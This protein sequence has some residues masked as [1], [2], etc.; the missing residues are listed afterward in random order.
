[1]ASKTP[2][3]TAIGRSPAVSAVST[4]S[5]TVRA[6]DLTTRV[7]A[8]TP[9]PPAAP[10]PL[11]AGLSDVSAA[12]T[13][14][15]HAI[16]TVR[17]VDGIV[18]LVAAPASRTSLF[19]ASR[20]GR[21]V[22]R[23][24]DLLALRIEL[25]NLKVTPGTP[26]LL[27]RNAGGAAYIV[28]HLPP[29]SIAEKVFFETA[30]PGMSDPDLPPGAQVKGSEPTTTDAPDPPPIRA[31][32]AGESRLVFKVPATFSVPYTLAGVLEACESL[33]PNV[34]ANAL[35]GSTAER[36]LTIKDFTVADLKLLSSAQRI[37]LS[38]LALRNVTV[39]AVDGA[40]SP[41][42][43]FRMQMT[44]AVS[45]QL[46][47][48]TRV[49]R[50]VIPSLPPRPAL[51]AAT[52]TA[53]ELPWRL[54]IAPHTGE[55]FRHAATPVTSALT[56]RTELWHSRL[57]A[58][59]A[60]G[61]WIE[62]PRPDPT[63]TTRAVWA[64]TGEGSDTAAPMS[65][66]FPT[67]GTLPTTDRVT[68]P[69]LTTLDDFDRYQIAHLSSNFS[70]SS[71]TPQP[72][73]TNLL[74]LSSLGGWLDARGAWDP[75]GLSV[76]EWVHRATM[77]RDHY[78]RVVYKGFLYPFGHRVALIK[79]SERKFHNGRSNTPVRA[80][81]PAYLRQRMFIIVRERER[82]FADGQ[83]RSADG[84]RAFQR[85][86]PFHQVRILTEV[87]P[88]LDPPTTT[89]S[90]IA[91]PPYA[92]KQGS[93]YF[94]Q[95]MFWPCVG[96]TPFRFRCVGTDSDGQRVQFELPLI[97]MDNSLASPRFL[98]GGK[99]VPLFADRT[100]GGKV[101]FGAETYARAA[102]DEWLARSDGGV[103][104]V[105]RRQAELKRQRVALAPS[106]KAGDTA[107]EVEVMEFGG[108]W[109]AQGNALRTY[110]N[111]LSRPV[112]YPSV[113]SV[114]VR[115]AALAQLGGANASNLLQWNGAYLQHGFD[116]PDVAPANAKNKGQVFAEVV[117]EQG[118]AALD[119]STQ[120]DR[121]GGFVMP[122]LKPSGLSRSLGPLTGPV[123]KFV[124][125]ASLG[126]TE[127]FPSSLS[128]LPLP[129]LFG[130]IP[131]GE[132][133]KAVAGGSDRLPK[134]ASEAGNKLES[135]FG[136]LTRVF[137]LLQQL[138]SQ[139]GSIAQAAVDVAKG[140]LQDLLAQ[141]LSLAAAQAAPVK[142]ALQDLQARLDA[143]RTR[144][145]AFVAP[146]S[147]GGLPT[148]DQV[149]AALTPAAS[150][151]LTQSLDQALASIAS[152]RTQVQAAT[153]PSGFQQSV[154][155]ACTQAQAM[156]T[157]LK[158]VL[159]VVAA[160][161]ALFDAVKA[162]V[163]DP[164][165]LTSGAGLATRLDAIKAAIDPLRG[166]LQGFR[167]LDG[168][169]RKT[170][171]DTLATVSEVLGAAVD[172]A[173]L[174][175]GLLGDELVV[176]FDWKPEID[177]WALPG[178]D[179]ATEPIFRANDKHGF[180]VAV[181]ARM[182]KSG[183]APK[184]GVVCSLK[185][186]DLVLINPAAFLE[187]NFE[188]I[189]FSVDSSAKMNVDVLLTDIKFVGPLSFVETLRDLIPLDGFS[190]PP[191]LD[192][193]PQ[194]IDAG[195]SVAL[196]NVSIG[197]FS[198]SNLSLGAGFTVPFIGQPLSV[199]FNFCTREQPFNLTVSLFGGGGFFGVTIDPHGVQI[200]EAAF[201]FGASIS[202]DFGV[203]SGGV[204]VMA[205]IYFRMERDAAS[206]TG[207]FR[208]GGHVSVLCLVSASLELYLEL[209]YEF[210]T[211]KAVGVAQLTIEISILMFSASVTIRCERKF[212]GSNGDPTFR[213]LMGAQPA[214][215]LAD[216]LA[217]IDGGTRYAWREYCEAFA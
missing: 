133:L 21:P 39:A 46:G 217:Q 100:V 12:K 146:T 142:A 120:G 55:R 93:T 72:L 140:M 151:Q 177:N 64:L 81:N 162:V 70:V 40:Q 91:R 197:V 83:L 150:T 214:L 158:A 136:A 122:N 108:E 164:D 194:G 92:P 78:V 144:F 107:A 80:G 161:K 7:V 62:P 69:F 119:F 27:E 88:N 172:L 45:S 201:E 95:S 208:L 175:D 113:R 66:T 23:P 111:N 29:Q 181:E 6:T 89:P 67:T 22:V 183:G 63:R 193:T 157:D 137:T 54:I 139:S 141:V 206:L 195:F 85:Q 106:L 121:S 36:T 68:G 30:A 5:S 130:C 112:F 2:K 13:A 25:V 97:F 50:I 34:P 37:A 35:A 170:L 163:E 103:P 192:I 82:S 143:V 31:R 145:D 153:L 76:E 129:L 15:L 135:F 209:R 166:A 61:D 116:A 90:R 123:E 9:P 186:F 86:L 207:Y 115:V 24:D 32:V 190:D 79:V 87:T 44:G 8:T 38:S 71:Y 132:V 211:G 203:A 180:V 152:L 171:L 17:I 43:A 118:M 215:A 52:Q 138:G 128:D 198:L 189:E 154:L 96:G 58:P 41:T 51:P 11:A 159:Q 28:L 148:L 182:K 65:G 173:Q 26:P 126:G 216:E 213:Q 117:P 155:S 178:A 204:H 48:L 210:S 160:T 14:E 167:L 169:P 75:P 202:V 196:P 49:D 20:P 101:E 59:D 187:L 3:P 125:G 42:L 109:Q 53:I 16:D 4:L 124:S 131:L 200:L 176:R 105:P 74:L 84:K 179:K 191:H 94:G 99:L 60:K 147:G 149:A 73:A 174:I 110:S 212:A 205:G 184:V 165:A 56:Q 33:A 199:R 168:A 114:R 57:V 127:M 134:F 47:T 19:D 102:T 104:A 1:M 18:D 98:S 185:H 10:P 156:L 77:G 188:K